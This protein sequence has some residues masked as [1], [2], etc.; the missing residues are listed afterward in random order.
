MNVRRLLA[1]LCH[2]IGG[3]LTAIKVPRHTY[4]I[5]SFDPLKTEKMP[6]SWVTNPWAIKL[7]VLGMKLD[8]EHWDHWGLQHDNCGGTPCPACGGTICEEGVIDLDDPVGDH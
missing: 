5:V 1:K 3:Q 7:I 8:G 6:R 2:R 4:R